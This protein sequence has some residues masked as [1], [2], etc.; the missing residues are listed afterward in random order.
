LKEFIVKLK[1]RD[2]GIERWTEE[3]GENVK[4]PCKDTTRKIISKLQIRV[5]KYRKS[6]SIDKLRETK[7]TEKYLLDHFNKLKQIFKENKLAATQM[8]VF[9]FFF[10][11]FNL[12]FNFKWNCDEVGVQL[13]DLDVNFG[14]LW[15][16]SVNTLMAT[17]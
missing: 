7:A 11:I 13:T 9:Y 5:R 3:N 17:K 6:I 10:F 2:L 8:Y 14:V 4:K 15:A 1:A 12:K 16:F